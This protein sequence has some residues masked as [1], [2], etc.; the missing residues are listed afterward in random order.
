MIPKLHSIKLIFYRLL[1]P[2]LSLLHRRVITPW[3]IAKHKG[4]HTRMLEIGPGSIRIPGFE[5]LNVV[6][7]PDVDYVLDASKALPFENESFDVVYASHILEHIPWHKVQQTTREWA[8]IIKPGGT[9]EIWVPDGYKLCR[10]MCDLDEHVNNDA[11]RDGWN[12][13]GLISDAY[14]WTNGRILY[15]ARD[16]YPSWHKA[17]LTPAF[18][19]KLLND[20]GLINIQKMESTSVRGYDHGWIN[21]GIKGQK[22]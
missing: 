19:I 13:S 2:C 14:T 20:A 10:L 16:D 12:P 17:I 22:P 3:N 18:L 9:L 8:R 6:L 21:L 11:W 1:F 5:T 4:D 15:G 7:A